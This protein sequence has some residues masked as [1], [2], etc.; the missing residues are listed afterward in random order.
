MER[1]KLLYLAALHMAL[2]CSRANISDTE[3]KYDYYRVLSRAEFPFDSPDNLLLDVAHSDVERQ[4]MF[5]YSPIIRIGEDGVDVCFANHREFPDT[6]EFKPLDIVSEEL[7]YWL[8]GT[9]GNAN[10]DELRKHHGELVD[11][12]GAYVHLTDGEEVQLVGYNANGVQA[13]IGRVRESGRGGVLLEVIKTTTT[14]LG[15]TLWEV[16]RRTTTPYPDFHTLSGMDAGFYTTI[17]G[18][19][20]EYREAKG[21]GGFI[22]GI[23]MYPVP[24][25]KWQARPM[26]IQ[27]NAET[28]AHVARNSINAFKIDPDGNVV[29]SQ[30]SSFAGETVMRV[31][32]QLGQLLSVVGN[33]T[34][35]LRDPKT[36]TV[37]RVNIR[38]GDVLM[39]TREFA[40]WIGNDQ[41]LGHQLIDNAM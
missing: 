33:T 2:Y 6:F 24:G 28:N 9:E 15:D 7:H 27:V 19:P 34:I 1:Y 32:E 23:G 21:F 40:E 22:L 13:I 18:K 35:G 29:A 8:A 38:H 11:L 4:T 10:L 30:S 17:D 14:Q 39:V 36:N 12:P 26:E 20:I 5:G 37:Q 25:H 3:G 31:A 16:R 41:T